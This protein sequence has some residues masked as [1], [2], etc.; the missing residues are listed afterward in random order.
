[1]AQQLLRTGQ[2]L[3]FYVTLRNITSVRGLYGMNIAKWLLQHLFCDFVQMVTVYSPLTWGIYKNPPPDVPECGFVGELCPSP[4]QGKLY[5]SIDRCIDVS[6]V[7]CIWYSDASSVCYV[8]LLR[9]FFRFPL[10]LWNDLYCVVRSVK[11]THVPD[12]CISHRC[13]VRTT[14]LCGFI[15]VLYFIRSI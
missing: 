14:W 10:C 4:V 11:L 7:L 13:R 12:F 6:Y 1:M 9:F 2:E 3:I 15:N 5:F 8:L